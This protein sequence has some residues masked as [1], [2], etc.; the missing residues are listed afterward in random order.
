[1]A[2]RSGDHRLFRRRLVRLVDDSTS[3]HAALTGPGI[4]T[5]AAIGIRFTRVMRNDPHG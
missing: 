3:G 4:V 5:Q 1:M 2:G